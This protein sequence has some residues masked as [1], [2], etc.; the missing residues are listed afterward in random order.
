MSELT[1]TIQKPNPGALLDL[2]TLDLSPVGLQV[3]YHF[4]AGTDANYGTISFGGV[5]Y[6]PW[7]IKMTGLEKTT[8]G[9]MGRPQLTLGNKDNYISSLCKL[10]L[11]LVNAQLVRKRVVSRFLDGEPGADP[12]AYTMEL[13]LVEQKVQETPL[14]VIFELSTPID[15]VNRKI[16]G[17]R[18]FANMCTHKYRRDAVAMFE[19]RY[20]GD[21][22]NEARVAE[23]TGCTWVVPETPGRWFNGQ[24]EPVETAAED[25]CGK[26]LVDCEARFGSGGVLPF[27]GWPGLNK[28]L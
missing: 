15:F 12:S 28:V 20:P 25:R 17:R 11:D 7:A 5:Q 16:P 21:P 24:G 6:Y 22:E 18:M 8:T 13:Y 1:A 10:Y 2:F 14:A 26:R 3:Q 9:A 23:C 4:Y 27:G 19:A